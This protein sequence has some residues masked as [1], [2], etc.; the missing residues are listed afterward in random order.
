MIDFSKWD[1][2]EWIKTEMITLKFYGASTE[3][4]EAPK[5]MVEKYMEDLKKWND[6]NRPEKGQL[7]Y[8]VFSQDLRKYVGKKLDKSP[9]KVG[10]YGPKE[11]P[12]MIGD[13]YDS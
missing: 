12:P 3:T 2:S 13:H 4:L 11:N 1:L 5:K 10:F 7:T 9:N 8:E 6:N